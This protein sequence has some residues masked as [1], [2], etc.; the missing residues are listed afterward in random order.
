MSGEAEWSG[1]ALC[2]SHAD[3]AVRRPYRGREVVVG[4]SW[5]TRSYHW[6]SG[7]L[8]AGTLRELKDRIDRREGQR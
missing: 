7:D 5:I 4:R 1:C 6:H 3:V 8:V 2:G